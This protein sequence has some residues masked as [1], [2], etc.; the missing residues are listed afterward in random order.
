MQVIG[1]KNCDTCRKAVKELGQA[2]HRVAL[3]DV[4]ENPLDAEE[5]AAHLAQFGQDLINRSSTTWRGL[6]EDDRALAPAD[7]LARYPAVMKRPVIVTAGGA[8]L[9][10]SAA[11]KSALL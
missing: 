9:G 11:V 10:W 2:G 3:R 7:L 5:I 6:S 4:R 1:L 8:Y